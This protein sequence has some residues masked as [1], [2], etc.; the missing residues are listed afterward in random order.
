VSILSHRQ[1][2]LSAHLYHA[3]EESQLIFCEVEIFI[4]VSLKMRGKAAARRGKNFR[5]RCFRAG[6]LFDATFCPP[7]FV[8]QSN[9]I[10]F[11]SR[12]ISGHHRFARAPNLDS[13]DN[14]TAR[15][16]IEKIE[17]SD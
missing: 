8:Q 2:S 1:T 13:A 12:L 10:H 5:A 7:V 4:R 14:G 9:A 3:N 16:Q 6:N 15:V 17:Q 11:V